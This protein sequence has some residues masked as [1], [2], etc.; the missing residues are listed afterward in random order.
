[1]IHGYDSMKLSAIGE[2]V[3]FPAIVLAIMIGSKGIYDTLTMGIQ[4][5]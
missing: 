4:I 2:L 5:N 1:M 3:H